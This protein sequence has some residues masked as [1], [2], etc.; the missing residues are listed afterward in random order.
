MHYKKKKEREMVL[1]FSQGQHFL[2]NFGKQ[3]TAECVCIA[4]K[5]PEI[6][7]YGII[8]GDPNSAHFLGSFLVLL[9]RGTKSTISIKLRLN[10]Q[11]K[12]EE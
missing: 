8:A 1:I 7:F 2:E 11:V 5:M 4:F 10:C 12:E 3:A 6:I 9:K